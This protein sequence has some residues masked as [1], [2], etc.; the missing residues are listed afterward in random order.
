MYVKTNVY[1]PR[2]KGLKI[3]FILRIETNLYH[4][5]IIKIDLYPSS[6]THKWHRNI[7]GRPKTFW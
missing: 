2:K 1:D 5:L 7:C 4:K 6:T 3:S